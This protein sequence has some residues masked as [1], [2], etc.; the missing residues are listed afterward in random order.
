MGIVPVEDRRPPAVRDDN[1]GHPPGPQCLAHRRVLAPGAGGRAV[2]A[3]AEG[4]Q[5]HEAGLLATGTPRGALRSPPA[6]LGVVQAV[7]RLPG[8]CRLDPREGR[9]HGQQHP[10]RGQTRP[11][12]GEPLGEVDRTG[13]EGHR[14]GHGGDDGPESDGGCHHDRPEGQHPAGHRRSARPGRAWGAARGIVGDAVGCKGPAA[15]VEDHRQRHGQAEEGDGDEA[16]LD[17]VVE[18]RCPVEE[19]PGHPLV[20]PLAEGEHGGHQ[21]QHAEEPQPP[22]A[23]PHEGAGDQDDHDPPPDVRRGGEWPAEVAA[24]LEEQAL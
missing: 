3:E 23:P 19:L 4:G 6:R 7:D 9:R 18:H 20:G 1:G 21:A 12:H 10:A 2:E 13:G 17:H 11:L 8:H 14:R 22:V 24:D 16:L 15:V 5:Q